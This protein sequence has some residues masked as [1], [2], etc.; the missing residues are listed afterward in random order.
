MSSYSVWHFFFRPTTWSHVL[1]IIWKSSSRRVE[2]CVEC[3]DSM[4]WGDLRAFFV[5]YPLPSFRAVFCQST[6]IFLYLSRRRIFCWVFNFGSYPIIMTSWGLKKISKKIFFFIFSI[7]MV[8]VEIELKMNPFK[9]P[10]M[11]IYFK[12]S[13]RQKHKGFNH[14]FENRRETE[15]G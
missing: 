7:F 13:R 1:Y 9:T 6:C 5:I 12:A 15:K 14:L 10:L 3:L 2:W 11:Y 4:P 8:T